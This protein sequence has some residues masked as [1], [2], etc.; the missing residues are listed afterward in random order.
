MSNWQGADDLLVNSGLKDFSNSFSKTQAVP[1][2]SRPENVQFAELS[3]L[4]IVTPKEEAHFLPRKL[5]CYKW[6]LAR[7]LLYRKTNRQK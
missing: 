4:N 3:I 5:M 1:L 6:R 7:D 2:K